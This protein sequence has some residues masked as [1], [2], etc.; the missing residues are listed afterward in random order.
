MEEFDD[1]LLGLGD[2]LTRCSRSYLMTS[3]YESI[4]DWLWHFS[5][6]QPLNWNITLEKKK[7]EVFLTYVLAIYNSLVSSS[8]LKEE[9]WRN[10]TPI[11]QPYMT[12]R[13]T[14]ICINMNA[15]IQSR[16][17][18]SEVLAI[19]Q[20]CKMPNNA[21]QC[22]TMPNNAKQAKQCQTREIYRKHFATGYR[23]RMRIYTRPCHHPARLYIISKP[24]GLKELAVPR[25]FIHI[26][27]NSINV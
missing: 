13:Y 15:T 9:K 7:S 17:I 18:N 3:V 25:I 20:I 10:S 1:L 6:R 22:Q 27:R 12:M 14:K 2:L 5:N 8:L 21:E 19:K 11:L 4:E 24:R 23:L 26:K 16:D